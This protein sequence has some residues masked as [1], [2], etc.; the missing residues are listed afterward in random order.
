[1]AKADP[2]RREFKLRPTGS[3]VRTFIHERLIPELKSH[4]TSINFRFHNLR[5]TF[6]LNLVE[7]LLDELEAGRISYLEL[8]RHVADRMGHSNTEVTER[9]ITYKKTRKL[10][11]ISQKKLEGH[12][13]QLISRAANDSQ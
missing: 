9:Y 11:S 4:G 2:Q 8:I 5:A 7:G 6:G 3:T 13:Y 12:L 1:M 10:I